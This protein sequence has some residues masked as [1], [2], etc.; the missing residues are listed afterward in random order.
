MATSPR[1]AVLDKNAPA[2]LR[3]IHPSAICSSFSNL[4][5]SPRHPPLVSSL[6]QAFCFQLEMQFQVETTRL[7]CSSRCGQMIRLLQSKSRVADCGLTG[8]EP[9]LC[10]LSTRSPLFYKFNPYNTTPS[11]CEPACHRHTDVDYPCNRFSDAFRQ[12]SQ[13]H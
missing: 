6:L 10:P 7:H 4:L 3:S 12:D 13:K 1:C 5:R 11:S 2:T 9:T 8:S